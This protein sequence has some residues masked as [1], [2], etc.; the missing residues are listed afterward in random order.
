MAGRWLRHGRWQQVSLLS[1]RSSLRLFGAGKG[2]GSRHCSGSASL[3]KTEADPGVTEEEIVV[4]RKKTWDKLAVLQTLASTV[5]RDPTAAHYMFQD[6]PYLIPRNSYE[7]RLFSLS[8]ESGKN[9]A[10]YIVNEFP[11]FFEKDIAEPHIPCLMPENL[12]PQIEEVSEAALKERIQLRRVKASVDMFDQLLQSGTPL[13]LETSNRLL[14][15]L[16]FYGDREPA[17]EDQSEQKE[18]LEESEEAAPDQRKRRGRSWKTSDFIGPKW[19][20]NNNAERI[21]NLMPERNAHSYCTMIRGM[22]KHG[23]CVRAHDMYTDLLND[24]HTA[25]VYTFSA[26][27]LAVPEVKE[28]YIERWELV[29]DLLKHMVQQ[30]VQPNLLTFNA[31]LKTLRKC[32]GMGKGISLKILREMKALNIEPSLAT[33]EHLLGIF[34]KSGSMEIIYE[35]MDEIEG[36]TFVAQDPDDAN[37]FVSAMRICHSL[38]DVELAYRLHKVL[39]TGDNWKLIGDAQQQS[40]YCARFFTLVCMM[41]Q[42]DVILKWY[43]ELVPSLFYPNAQVMWDLLQ[44]LDTANHLEMVPQ[45]WKDIKQLGLSNRPEL[46]EEVLALM[47][48]EIHS[49]ETQMSFANCAADIKSIFETRERNQVPLGWTASALGNIAILFSRVG[50]I[51][52]ACNMLELFKRTSRVPSDKVMNEVLTCAKQSN[53][54]HQA[55]EL[56]KLAAAFSL[57]TTAKLARRVIEEFELSEEQKKTLEDADPQS[58]DSS[59]SDSD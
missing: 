37:F 36:K 44:A 3:Q 46:L 27:I 59:D 45:F 12:A 23:A 24:R 19:R 50:R 58:S 48:R 13:S 35:V 55:V 17:R 33:F 47:A 54:P 52:E 14:D 6:D 42:L 29:E 25:D 28:N 20:E 15:L 34:Y 26:L 31:V 5:N 32:G 7:Y 22:V 41:E 39:E 40:L 38:K 4:P 2:E 1:G 18:E 30:K 43:K 10:R 8:K 51:Q 56:V 49:Q 57:P 21:F 16:C 9:A 11:R 53:T